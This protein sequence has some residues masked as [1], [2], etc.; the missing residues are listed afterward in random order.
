MRQK[1][2]ENY[3]D[4]AGIYN[5]TP[6]ILNGKNIY[7]RGDRILGWNA[8]ANCWILTAISYRDGICSSPLENFGGFH[9]ST[10]GEAIETTTWKHYHVEDI[11]LI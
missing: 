9:F 1:G 2:T 3:A 5:R 10:G 8:A 4:C 7:E 11:V 6:I